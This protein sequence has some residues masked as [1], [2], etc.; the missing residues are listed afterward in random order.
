[1][2]FSLSRIVKSMVLLTM[3]FIWYGCNTAVQPEPPT[4]PADEDYMVD[5]TKGE[6]IWSSAATFTVNGDAVV[7]TFPT[8]ISSSGSSAWGINLYT[9][10]EG[11]AGMDLSGY[12]SIEIVWSATYPTDTPEQDN[13]GNPNKQIVFNLLC[14]GLDPT[15]DKKL[16]KYPGV[17]AEKTEN[18]SLSLTDE[19][20]TTD[21]KNVQ[22]LVFQSKV[23]GTVL[24]IKSITFKPIKTGGNVFSGSVAFWVSESVTKETLPTYQG[25]SDALKIHADSYS[26]GPIRVDLSDYA[27]KNVT[28]RVSINVWMDQ[29]SKIMWQTDASGYP[30]IAGGNDSYAAN[31]WVL[32]EGE[33]TATLRDIQKDGEG[34]ITGCPWFYLDHAG[35]KGGATYY[36]ADLKLEIL[37]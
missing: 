8:G 36:F 30:V 33:T 15:G 34:N 26:W 22:Q 14:G 27:E 37:E 9:G 6:T 29:P 16:S 2:K 4:E 10:E 21:K 13:E 17:E 32:F 18:I 28:L 25:K 1:M 12:G 7:I 5:L 20:T 35:L 24:T 3:A 11:T 23:D 19:F 31:E